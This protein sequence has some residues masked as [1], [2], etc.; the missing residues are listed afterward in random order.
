MPRSMEQRGTP[1]P[2]ERKNNMYFEMLNSIFDYVKETVDFLDG[3]T[4]EQND[5]RKRFL[6][7]IE[8]APVFVNPNNIMTGN[9]NTKQ[10]QR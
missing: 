6:E 5:T 4:T 9:S 3:H 7:G 2:D 1:L 10:N 8:Q